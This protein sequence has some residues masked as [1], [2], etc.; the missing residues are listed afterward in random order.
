MTIG[1]N[2]RWCF[3]MSLFFL[4]FMVILASGGGSEEDPVPSDISG[5]WAFTSTLTS[6]NN[7]EC[8]SDPMTVGDR[9][10][11][12]VTII[13]EADAATLIFDDGTTRI[14][15]IVGNTLDYRIDINERI[16]TCGQIVHQQAQWTFDGETL[17]GTWRFSIT[18]KDG[19][20]CSEGTITDLLFTISGKRQ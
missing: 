2:Q 16:G 17:S 12:S 20:T 8:L 5:L 18:W 13:T 14:G 7:G 10:R 11:H 4:G 19:C 6:L 15:N 1:K 9:Q 3:F